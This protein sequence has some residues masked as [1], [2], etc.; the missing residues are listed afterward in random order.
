MLILSG[1]RFGSNAIVTRV[2][3]KRHCDTGAVQLGGQGGKQI[4]INP[5]GVAHYRSEVYTKT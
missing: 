2:A 1:D 3:V 5:Y 4:L